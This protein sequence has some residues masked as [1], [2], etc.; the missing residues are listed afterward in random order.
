[1]Y[2]TRTND[3]LIKIIPVGKASLYAGQ[4]REEQKMISSDELFGHGLAPLFRAQALR[5]KGGEDM[6]ITTSLTPTKLYQ[7]LTY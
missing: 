1:M 2:S 3:K 6:G 5:S 4:W 7:K